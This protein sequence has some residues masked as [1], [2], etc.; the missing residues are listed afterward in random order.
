MLQVDQNMDSLRYTNIARYLEQVFP[1]AESFYV[2]TVKNQ[3]EKVKKLANAM[4]KVSN[5]KKRVFFHED[6]MEFFENNYSDCE[7]FDNYFGEIFALVEQQ[8]LVNADEFCQWP[9]SSFSSLVKEMRVGIGKKG[10]HRFSLYQI[11][12]DSKSNQ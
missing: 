1:E 8:V 12:L 6:L 7:L 2:A 11:L 3:Y 4:K 5:G 9:K 10:V